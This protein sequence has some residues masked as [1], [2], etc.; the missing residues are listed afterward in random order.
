MCP[1]DEPAGA[2]AIAGGIASE[3]SPGELVPQ[4]SQ[5]SA[6]PRPH[7]SRFGVFEVFYGVVDAA[8]G[9]SK[10]AEVAR[11]WEVDARSE[12]TE[13]GEPLFTRKERW[14]QP[15]GER[16]VG[17]EVARVGEQR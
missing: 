8:Q 16:H 7:R 2:I 10:Q 17:S 13:E 4:T 11:I 15:V 9:F 6:H 12:R 5:M 14:V 1:R 3:E